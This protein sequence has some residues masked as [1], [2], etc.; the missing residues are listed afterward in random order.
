M[1]Q[2]ATAKGERLS[3]AG[4]RP[5]ARRNGWC[6]ARGGRGRAR[7]HG[8]APGR[9]RRSCARPPPGDSGRA[10]PRRPAAARAGEPAAAPGRRDRATRRR[11]DEPA[12]ERGGARDPAA[13]WSA[14]SRRSS[15]TWPRDV[16]EAACEAARA[17]GLA[18]L[19]RLLAACAPHAGAPGRPSWCPRSSACGGCGLGAAETGA[20]EGF[21][22][23]DRELAGL[24]DELSALQWSPRRT[25]RGAAPPVA[26]LSL[27][28]TL[29]ELPLAD[30]AARE[31]ARRARLLPPVAAALRAALDWL[32]GDSGRP[33]RCARRTRSSR[34]RA[35]TSTSARSPR[36]RRCSPRWE[37]TSAPARARSARGR[38]GCR[39]TPAARST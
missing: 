19:E 8:D 21:R 16:V 17:L 11:G 4:E 3:A 31:L 7:R 5:R 6:A 14:R 30:D 1:V 20:L 33:S 22:E 26:T 38:S 39:S 35:S 32:T 27:A 36:R 10:A 34:C 13:A 25:A 23:A 18:G 24:A 15:A 29:D 28:G 2:D 9:A 37:R 12:D